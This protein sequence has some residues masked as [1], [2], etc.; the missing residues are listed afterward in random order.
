MKLQTEPNLP[1]DVAG[2]VRQLTEL[3]RN[4]AQQVN[5]LTE[6]TVYAVHNSAL[7]APTTGK[8]QQGDTL[9]NRTPTELGVAASMYVI[10][11]WCCVIAGEPGTWVELRSLTGN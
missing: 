1:Q 3:H 7:A 11:G 2:L 9:R 8:Y 5:G 4:T 6:G 10:T